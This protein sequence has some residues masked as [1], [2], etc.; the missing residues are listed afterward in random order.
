MKKLLSI[1]AAILMLSHYAFAQQSKATIVWDKLIELYERVLDTQWHERKR[2]LVE[3][4]YELIDEYIYSDEIKARRD[5]YDLLIWLQ[6]YLVSKEYFDTRGMERYRDDHLSLQVLVPTHTEFWMSENDSL[7]E[8]EVESNSVPASSWF[9]G[10]VHIKPKWVSSDDFPSWNIT[11]KNIDHSRKDE[12]IDEFVKEVY[13]FDC[14]YWWEVIDIDTKEYAT[15]QI[16]PSSKWVDEYWENACIMNYVQS[17][18]YYE[19]EEYDVIVQWWIWHD[20]NFWIGQRAF[21]PI[22]ND[23]F[24]IV[25]E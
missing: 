10:S 6:K 19:W 14:A 2:F 25:M 17:L 20:N 23:S 15:I 21:D 3:K 8:V 13:W 5:K 18:R 22:M 11:I 12:M 24:K 4:T 1:F 7:M 9:D 16:V